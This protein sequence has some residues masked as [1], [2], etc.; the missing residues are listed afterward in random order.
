MWRRRTDIN[1]DLKPQ[2]KT[3]QNLRGGGSSVSWVWGGRVMSCNKSLKK[4]KIN[5]HD[6][7]QI[8]TTQRVSTKGKK[9]N[10]H[11]DTFIVNVFLLR[12]NKTS[13]IK[14]PKGKIQQNCTNHF[15]ENAGLHYVTTSLLP[16]C[17]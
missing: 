15:M 2:T 4:L 11:G 3:N 10:L 16:Y 14:S 12:Q 8:L 17:D 1:P 7:K 6:F 13:F 5:F 9:N